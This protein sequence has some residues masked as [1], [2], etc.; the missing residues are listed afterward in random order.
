MKLQFLHTK[1]LSKKELLVNFYNFHKIFRNFVDLSKNLLS[2]K[3]KMSF[4]QTRFTEKKSTANFRSL[5]FFLANL[6]KN[7]LLFKVFPNP[8]WNGMNSPFEKKSYN[9]SD[10][11]IPASSPCKFHAIPSSASN[12]AS[13]Y[14]EYL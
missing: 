1:Y 6:C 3:E 2:K 8:C 9:F 14:V 13:I 12:L 11:E 4:W 5:D 10:L 7:M